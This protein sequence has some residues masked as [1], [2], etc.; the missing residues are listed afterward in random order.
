MDVP[1]GRYIGI[2]RATELL[3]ERLDPDTLWLVEGVLK[4]A[5]LMLPV[6]LVHEMSS[7]LDLLDRT[8]L[9]SLTSQSEELKENF[10]AMEPLLQE[11]GTEFC[12]Q[13]LEERIIGLYEAF[14]D[15]KHDF[16]N[17]REGR[18]ERIRELFMEVVKSPDIRDALDTLLRQLAQEEAIPRE[19][20]SVDRL[21]AHLRNFVESELVPR[22]YV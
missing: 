22:I 11:K 10:R 1:V 8:V 9:G 18:E 3:R 20:T 17:W 21:P 7:F 6:D 19:W 12:L 15:A 5:A 2:D 16:I 13:L 4:N 14:A